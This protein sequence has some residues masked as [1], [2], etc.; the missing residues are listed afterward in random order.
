MS[1]FYNCEYLSER[2]SAVC[3]ERDELKRIVKKQ[4]RMNSVMAQM[5]LELDNVK[6]ERDALL[7]QLKG[8]AG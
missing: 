5:A 3:K 1:E 4:A 2:L 7:A 6:A 8:S